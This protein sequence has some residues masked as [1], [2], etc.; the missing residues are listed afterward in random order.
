LFDTGYSG[1]LGLDK[2]TINALN[3]PNIGRGKGITVKG[4]I[5]YNNY[6]G[7]MEIVDEN[8]K[9][10]ELIKNIDNSEDQKDQKKENLVVIQEF[11]IPIMGIKSIKQFSWLILGT[12][13][14]IYLI[15]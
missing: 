15:K 2:D 6:A 12:E 9:S 8:G 1:Y 14:V 11:D 4:I 5:D 10:I 7:T 13:K 3:L